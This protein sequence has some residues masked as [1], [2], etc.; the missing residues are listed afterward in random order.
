MWVD[1]VESWIQFLL[2]VIAAAIEL[3]AVIDAL[4]RPAA[5]FTAAEKLT[6]PGWIIILLLSL[7][8]SYLILLSSFSIFALAG[9]VAAGVYLA[10]VR[11]AVAD[12]T[13]R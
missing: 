7:L 13:R 12:V 5:G 10:D 1:Q 9:V 11:P 6:K 3:F 8:S 4:M 2:F